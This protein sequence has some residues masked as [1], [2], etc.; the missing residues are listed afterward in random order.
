MMIGISFQAPNGNGIGLASYARFLNDGLTLNGFWRTAVM[1]GLVA[2]VATGFAYPI[3]Y[4][5]ARSKSRWRSVVFALALAPELAGV[6]LRTYGW[7]IILEDRGFINDSLIYIGAI[8]EPLPL[9]KNLFAVV[10]GLTHVV[11]P[12]AVLS[13]TTSIQGIDGNLERAAQML[14]ASRISVLRYILLPL[15]IPGLVSSM[16]L[17]FTMAA[18]AYATPALLGGAAFKVLATMISEQVLFYVDW[19]FAAAMS[20][21]L[22]LLMLTVSYV[23]IRIETRLRDKRNGA[24][25]GR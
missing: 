10:V 17:S 25:G 8:S 2:F 16:L 3:A 5:L 14:G 21:V 4:F 19:P 18:S 9:S 1:S 23:G 24:T 11:L 12:F 6:V 13:L 7:L 15:S 20:N 22:F